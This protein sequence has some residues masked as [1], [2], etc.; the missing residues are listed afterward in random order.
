MEIYV[1]ESCAQQ[2]QNY[3]DKEKLSASLTEVIGEGEEAV[4][5]ETDK[6]IIFEKEGETLALEGIDGAPF[7][8]L[9]DDALRQMGIPER[10]FDHV[11][12]ATDVADL[13][14]LPISIETRL[15]LDQWLVQHASKKRQSPVY[16]EAEDETHLS[17]FYRRD[18][19][20]L[21]LRLE[22]EQKELMRKQTDKSPILV[23]GVVGSGKTT[24]AIYR[25]RNFA[26][27][28]NRILYLTYNHS[29]MEAAETL[30]SELSGGI[31]KGVEISTLHRWCTKYLK[32]HNKK[33]KPPKYH[34]WQEKLNDLLKQAVK[35]VQQDERSR[36]FS[37]NF[38]FWRKEIDEIIKGRAEAQ[39][40]QYMDVDRIGCG[41]SL[42]Q[43]ARKIVWKVYE[44]YERLKNWRDDY[45][46][47]LVKTL[48][49]LRTSKCRKYDY[50]I[51]DEAQD[52]YK[53]AFSI[54]MQLVE[55]PNRLFIV[56]DAAQSIYQS[57]FSWADIG[58]TI[59]SKNVYVLSKNHRNTKQILQAAQSFVD[60]NPDI[61]DMDNI[62]DPECS[63]KTGLKPVLLK[64]DG[65]FQDQIEWIVDDISYRIDTAS[66]LRK[67]IGVLSP[68]TYYAKKVAEKLEERGIN[69]SF[70]KDSVDV[71]A[72][73]VK[74]ITLQSSKGLEFP[75]VYI[76]G[77]DNK[78]FLSGLKNIDEEERDIYV[79]QQKK[80]L[81]VAMTRAMNELIITCDHRDYCDFLKDIN[82][83]FINIKHLSQKDVRKHKKQTNIE[84]RLREDVIKNYLH[85]VKQRDKKTAIKFAYQLYRT[86]YS[87][88]KYESDLDIEA[89]REII[90]KHTD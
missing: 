37:R 41:T 1:K 85:F 11:R 34:K 6:Q 38:S 89:I 15:K 87:L 71:N 54:A 49:T 31:P 42:G 14:N 79:T 9:E 33:V 62:L 59:G 35:N 67:N 24:I 63:V 65:S 64:F 5:I 17:R 28:S 56:A 8:L 82:Q 3:P 23:K 30:I 44:E 46:D 39:F 58:V 81:Y 75:L 55:D 13:K 60:K 72:N 25:M 77:A 80:L 45:I 69:A 7:T 22:D 70:Y 78:F 26:N 48:E 76:L 20:Q 4:T 19:V 66:C 51:I 2:L 90:E 61:A 10:Y 16:Y 36:L 74:C 73:T 12:A 29:L 47:I 52:L 32:R 84:Q 50:V 53:I 27:D 68:R 86:D 43:Q 40:D 83:N 88:G 57:G 21:L 18:I